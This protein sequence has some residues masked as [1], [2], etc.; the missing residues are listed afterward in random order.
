MTLSRQAIQAFGGVPSFQHE[1]R[2]PTPTVPPSLTHGMSGLAS[3]RQLPAEEPDLAVLGE[4]P[5]TVRPGRAVSPRHRVA[6]EPSESESEAREPERWTADKNR[7]R[8]ILIEMQISG[9]LSSDEARELEELQTQMLAFRRRVAPLPLDDLRA[10]HQEL[11]ER[12][13]S[14]SP[15]K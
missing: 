5:R 4:G 8:S 10:L 11:L 2:L 14:E 6:P 15:Q 7:R 12:V 9:T 3:P 1:F 13:S